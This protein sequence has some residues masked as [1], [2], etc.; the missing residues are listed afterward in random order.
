MKWNAERLINEWKRWNE[1]W[2]E[3]RWEEQEG[4]IHIGFCECNTILYEHH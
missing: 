3:K 1:K 4:E 2:T